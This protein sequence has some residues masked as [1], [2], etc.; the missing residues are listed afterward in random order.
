MSL[1]KRHVFSTPSLE[2]AQAVVDAARANGV[3]RDCICIEARSD[4]EVSRIRDDRKNVS[5]DFVPAALRG[6]LLGALAGLA[7]GLIGMNIPFFGLSG[8][9]ALALMVIGAL[10]GTWASVLIGSALPDEV[11][12]TFAEE[13]EAG[14]IL[15][16]IDAEVEEFHAFERAIAQAGGDRLP[17]EVNAALT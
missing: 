7:A 4:I 11:R 14:R 13:I 5:M 15:V 6:T 1:R 17:Y 2:V 3:G 8:L 10:V 9:G 16:V 12:R